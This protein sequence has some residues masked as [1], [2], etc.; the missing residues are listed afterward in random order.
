MNYIGTPDSGA[1]YGVE[2]KHGD[3]ECAGNIHQLCVQEHVRTSIGNETLPPRRKASGVE[4][5]R[6]TLP[7]V[8]N[9]IQAQNYYEPRKIGELEYAKRCA[10][11]AGVDWDGSGVA[12]CVEMAGSGKGG[13]KQQ[14]AEEA[15]EGM[16]DT[17]EEDL[18]DEEEE[19]A[20]EDDFEGTSSLVKAKGGWLDWI[21]SSILGLFGA[22]S[23]SSRVSNLLSTSMRRRP[24]GERLLISSAQRVH[25]TLH[26]PKSCTI[27][28][29]GKIR[30][31]HD[32]SWYQ[33]DVSEV[34]L[35]HFRALNANM[36]RW[37]CCRGKSSRGADFFFLGTV[38]G[39]TRTRGHRPKHSRRLEELEWMRDNF[40]L[41]QTDG[42]GY[43]ATR[44]GD[45]RLSVLPGRDYA[46]LGRGAALDAAA[47]LAVVLSHLSFCYCYR[48]VA[49]RS[50]EPRF[51]LL[52]CHY[53]QV[54]AIARKSN[55]ICRSGRLVHAIR[56]FSFPLM[57]HDHDKI[58]GRRRRTMSSKGSSMSPVLTRMFP[59]WADRHLHAQTTLW[60][61]GIGAR[62]RI[63]EGG[64]R[65]SY[66][67]LRIVV[68]PII[69]RDIQSS[70][71]THWLLCW[72]YGIV[73]EE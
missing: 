30:C 55:L 66:R 71:S 1:T 26:A 43:A 50:T 12:R 7:A 52:F 68:I 48:V 56:F 58:L 11:A 8:W 60:R 51:S 67:W 23:K 37:L 19:E 72:V 69:E 42:G 21:S 16:Y 22:S 47:I 25:S 65:S 53:H 39:R 33:C 6:S 54:L 27:L 4:G 24:E 61:L 70:R 9:F 62:H 49:P 17:D 35:P 64:T 10:V 31:I 14:T 3:L 38:L 15:E 28:I 41:R 57:Q 2:C 40:P 34:L 44:G 32:G 45:L 13:G 18:F 73:A 20:Y 46:L 36:R 63:S 5:E 59:N 29:E